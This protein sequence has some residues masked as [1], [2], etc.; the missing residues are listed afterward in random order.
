MKIN[1][2]TITSRL[3]SG[4][5][6]LA[7]A[8]LLSIAS[9]GAQMTPGAGGQST[10][11]AGQTTPGGQPGAQPGMSPMDQATSN[12]GQDPNGSA[13]MMDKAFVRTAL[14][15]GMAE[16]QLGQLAAQ[17]GNSDDVK[18]FGQKMVDD[19]TKLGE[20][21][22]PIAEQMGVNPPTSLSSKDKATMAKLQ[23]LNG[24]AFDKAYIK[25]M[26]KD[27]TKDDKDF[28]QEANRTTDP[29]LKQCVT[30]GAQVISEHLQMIKQIAQKNNVSASK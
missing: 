16:I 7:T 29:Q 21:L 1:C 5:M 30:Q 22:K 12:N 23:A 13:R 20:Q 9:A 18:Q 3:R 17:K 2:Q 27:H 4:P 14:E 15:G 8:A 19:H 28:K 6:V 25:D 10:S 24:D 26:V 11:P